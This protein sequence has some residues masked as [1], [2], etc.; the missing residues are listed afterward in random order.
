[1]RQRIPVHRLGR[2]AVH[3]G[4]GGGLAV[5]RQHAG[6]HGD[7]GDGR[8]AA[9]LLAGADGARGRQAVHLRH[10]HVHQDQVVA[11]LV[12]HAQRGGAVAG[13]LQRVAALVHQQGQ[14]LQVLR[15]VVGRQ[16]PQR[17]QR[18]G[19]ALGAL[20]AV[21]AGRLQRQRQV[22]GGAHALYAFG[23]QLAAHQRHQ[24]AAD[25]G[26][27]AGAAEAPRHRRVGLREGIEDR[28]QPLRRDADAGVLHGDPQLALGRAGAQA[29]AAGGGELD[30]VVEQVAEDLA[31]A[32]LVA[33]QPGRQRRLVD[34]VDAKALAAGVAAEGGGQFVD[35]AEQAVV[36]R[37]QLHRALV[38]LGGVEDFV[39]QAQQRAAFLAHRVQVAPLVVVEFGVQQHVGEAEDGVHRRADFMAHIGDEAGARGGGLF[40]RLL[41]LAQL[42]L[43]LA[44]LADVED[45]AVDPAQLG[46]AL[47]LGD[48]AV[49]PHPAGVAV[50]VAQPV[51]DLVGA[52][53]GD[54]AVDLGLD[55]GAVFRHD[56][57]AQCAAAL[58]A[59]EIAGRVAGQALDAVADEH[60]RRVEA[61]AAAEGYAGDVADQRA[62][63]LL[64]V[65]QRLHD[66]APFAD[67][68]DEQHEQVALGQP[69]MAQRAP[70][71]HAAA[72]LA[73]RDH[74]AALAGDGRVFGAQ[75]V[76]QAVLLGALGVV[77]QHADIAADDLVAAPAEDAFGRGVE[78]MD[79]AG[80]VDGDDA[81][82][83][84]GEQGAHPGFAL[85]FLAEQFAVAQQAV[86]RHDED[87]DGDGD[88]RDGQ[89]QEGAALFGGAAG[90]RLAGEARGRHAGVVHAGDGAAHDGGADR[91]Q[92]A[93]RQA[94]VQAQA[95]AHP[96]R[97]RG[98][99]HGHH[100]GQAEHQRIVVQRERHA[101]RGH[102]GVVHGADAGADQQAAEQQRAGAELAAADDGQGD[103]GRGQAGQ[104]G[105]HGD[106]VVVVDRRA[107]VERQHADEV[108][109]PDAAAQRQ[110]AGAQHDGAQ[111]AA[112]AGLG[113]GDHLQS[114][115]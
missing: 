62:E 17:R 108:H 2:E 34:D 72:V 103:A 111:A 88:Q 59:D 9:R 61:H 14:Q 66:G 74:L 53:V 4:G 44:A 39:E 41:G 20:A 10:L 110:A 24:L 42:L 92:H 101:H 114:H 67:V 86:G 31:H 38:Q 80:A 5:R 78:F 36:V 26:A 55:A 40:G 47:V 65:A 82:D 16:H 97:Q 32:Q 49:L 109:G 57:A 3:A 85:A 11:A 7:D 107:Q 94:G 19:G 15:H 33:V 69:R 28:L 46:I 52:E 112:L 77:H 30:G 83:G 76:E 64:A 99:H 98:Q 27:Q 37:L 25:G 29:D 104:H 84:G 60:R 87:G 6:R 106:D 71:R 105:Q 1:M 12:R 8:R 43:H 48:G 63:L 73:Q 56:Q 51:F 58:V 35:Q 23:P 45:D 100:D 91:A 90:L 54:G 68:G 93:G 79:H 21:V 95:E 13:P 18:I 102:A 96:Q 89:R 81:V 115:P 50:G 75:V 70:D 22:E 113:L